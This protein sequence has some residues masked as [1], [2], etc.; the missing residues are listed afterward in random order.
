M[1]PIPQEKHKKTASPNIERLLELHLV[2]S[3]QNS[4]ET[5]RLLEAHLMK[6]H[7]HIKNAEIAADLHLEM[8]GKTLAAL[9]A[10]KDSI[11]TI[12]ETIKGQSPNIS[13]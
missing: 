10:L 11:D 5:N 9:N 6:V 13:H 2:K 12:H 8:Q 1:T 3:H 4:T 7:Q